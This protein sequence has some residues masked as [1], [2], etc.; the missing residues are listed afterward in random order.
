MRITK[1]FGVI[2]GILLLVSGLSGIVYNQLVLQRELTS[3]AKYD[4]QVM[5]NDQK[6]WSELQRLAT[7]SATPTGKEVRPTVTPKAT[8]SAK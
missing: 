2:V 6:V 7:V 8:L 4:V 5:R 3:Q 1:R